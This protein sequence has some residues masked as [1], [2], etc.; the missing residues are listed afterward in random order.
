MLNYKHQVFWLVFM[1]F[2][3]RTTYGLRAVICLAQNEK[4]GNLSL[5]RIAKE[6][7]ISLP[8]LERI[9]V[10]LKKAR[11]VKSVKGMRGGYS[12]VRT[13]KDINIWDLVK[14]LEGKIE[15]FSCLGD[16]GRIDCGSRQPC[17]AGIVLSQVQKAIYQTLKNIKLSDLL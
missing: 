4:Q 5:A 13:A 15:M 12:L 3:T 10:R 17:G 16:D 1:K 7:K 8:Y 9:F 6:E 2:S 14:V 11:L